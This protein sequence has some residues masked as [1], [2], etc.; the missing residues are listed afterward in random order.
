MSQVDGAAAQAPS[1]AWTEDTEHDDPTLF[2]D[3]AEEI[4]DRQK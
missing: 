3:F 2:E 4:K 1:T